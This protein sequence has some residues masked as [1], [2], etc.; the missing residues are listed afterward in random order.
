ML[1]KLCRMSF[2]RRRQAGQVT[3]S[4]TLVLV[5][6]FA[7]LWPML[8]LGRSTQQAITGRTS[9]S[10]SP[11]TAAPTRL[12]SR[13]NAGALSRLSQFARS[14]ATTAIDT[15][16]RRVRGLTNRVFDGSAP[17]RATPRLADDFDFSRAFLNL[18]E[19]LRGET[20]RE[21][22]GKD[23]DFNLLGEQLAGRKGDLEFFDALSDLPKQPGPR[24]I[25]MALTAKKYDSL[26]R[27]EVALERAN[28]IE[29][30]DE[31]A[32]VLGEIARINPPDV[33]WNDILF[34]AKDLPAFFH[35]EIILRSAKAN[36]AERIWRRLVD[37]AD[38]LEPRFR[39]EALTTLA[40]AR[41]TDLALWIKAVESLDALPSPERGYRLATIGVAEPPAK[42]WPALFEKM[43]GL[44]DVQRGTTL[45]QLVRDGMRETPTHRSSKW[46][47]AFF[48][49]FRRKEG[50][51][52]QQWTRLTK[53]AQ[54]VED[55]YMKTVLFST[56]AEAAT[57]IEGRRATRY[58]RKA[59]AAA[60]AVTGTD[61]QVDALRS[62]AKSRPPR[63][64]HPRL[65]KLIG[66]LEHP[67]DRFEP[68]LAAA[69]NGVEDAWNDVLS[70]ANE[71]D[72]LAHLRYAL[73]EIVRTNPPEAL[74]H[75][76]V[77]QTNRLDDRAR[78]TVLELIA[79]RR[80][81]TRR[82]P[83]D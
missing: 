15:A 53:A 82:L 66:A 8:G 19:G 42:I 12:T 74:L 37:A 17:A 79:E 27:W 68:S 43:G 50:F 71:M 4:H 49:F 59:F 54:R 24:A 83:A 30:V 21:L 65:R 61:Q 58:W 40:A 28:N 18:P 73:S 78:A 20:L 34:A 44:S 29:F 67:K 31:R 70:S 62:I 60:E 26:P 3:V 25:L 9:A 51:L 16:G 13:S 7:A 5:A 75:D 47:R 76:V 77:A 39:T 6:A 14:T 56:I 10:A 32:D 55:P 23:G 41:R 57:N 46:K 64:F 52:E 1:L 33:I 35:R 69:Q 45:M 81:E 72:D 22:A 2:L 38:T 36:P 11:S 48:T 63:K 80:I